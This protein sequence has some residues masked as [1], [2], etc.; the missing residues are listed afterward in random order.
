MEWER[1]RSN[2]GNVFR[3]AVPGGWLVYVY[4]YEKDLLYGDAVPHLP[5]AHSGL[6]FYPDPDHKWNV[7]TA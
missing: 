3:A 7:G 5:W 6:T 2:L 4:Q 1:I